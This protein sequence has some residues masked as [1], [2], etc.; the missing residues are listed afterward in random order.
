LR[1]SSPATASTR[2]LA[3]SCG[4]QLKHAPRAFAERRLETLQP[5]E[6]DVWRS[7]LPA[8]LAHYIFRAFR[9]VLEYAVS[10]ELIESNPTARI[11][12][13]RAAVRRE[14]SVRVLAAVGG[15]RGGE[16]PFARGSPADRELNAGPRRLFVD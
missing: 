16:G 6:L 11:R 14:M 10:M 15:D 12:D 4:R 7:Q 1:R 8:L 9:Q 3:R 2:R 13:T 5:I